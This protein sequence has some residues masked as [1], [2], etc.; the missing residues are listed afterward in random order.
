M[1]DQAQGRFFLFIGTL[2]NKDAAT[3][4]LQASGI[5][6]RWKRLDSGPKN[7]KAILAILENPSIAG[8]VG[9]LSG[10]VYD[11]IALPD[12]QEITAP[13]FQALGNVP[14]VMFVHEAILRRESSIPEDRYEEG[15]DEYYRA[16]ERRHFFM[17]PAE[18]TMRAVGELFANHKV[19]VVPYR[20]NAEL[21]VLAAAFIDDNEKNLLFRVYVPSG[22]LYAAEADKLLSLFQDWLTRVGR[23]DVRQ[24][25]YRTAA[26]EV[27]EFFG[28]ESL[29]RGQLSREFD[30]FSGFLDLCV[31][32]VAAAADALGRT[33]IDRRSAVSI[34][35]RYGKEVRRLNL[36]M[37]QERES[38]ILA[39][40]HSLESEL[41]EVGNESLFSRIDELIEASVPN[42]GGLAPMQFLALGSSVP[43][44]AS[45]TVNINQQV[46]NAVESA[47]VQSIQG[48]TNIGP[49]AKELLGLVSRFGGQDTA[50]LESA[51]HEF[52]D[53]DA[54][55]SD[56]L[57]A[58]QRLKGFLFQL[59]GKVEDTALAILQ[60]YVQSKIG[61]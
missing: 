31:Q 46:V 50:A 4:K 18:E 21:S 11:L 35:A 22:R 15:T 47:V 30:D 9:K 38:R 34:V 37:R 23:H 25:G 13:L 49:E 29:V 14:H 12:Y 24:D 48:T 32:D 10:H 41:I 55:A 26:G 40:R 51:V 1:S 53:P 7:W 2:W 3:D 56:R 45:V 28:D 33:G 52:E 5:P 8:V 42:V 60:N 16:Q 54:R 59:G 57:G 43:R 61:L 36:D 27:Y 6:Y 58:R 17:L 44:S 19:N 20:T 39:I